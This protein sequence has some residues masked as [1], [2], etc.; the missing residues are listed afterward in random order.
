MA[1]QQDDRPPKVGPKEPP[2]NTLGAGRDR[3][4]RTDPALPAPPEDGAHA[5]EMLTASA[6]LDE[7]GMTEGR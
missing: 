5:D 2:S 1:N 3:E 7:M 4:G 6:D